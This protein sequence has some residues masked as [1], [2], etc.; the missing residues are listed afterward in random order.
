MLSIIPLLGLLRQR[1]ERDSNVLESYQLYL[2]GP[3]A[4][5]PACATS[6]VRDRFVYFGIPVLL[7]LLCL[8]RIGVNKHLCNLIILIGDGKR[9][10]CQLAIWHEHKQIVINDSRELSRGAKTSVGIE[11]VVRA[12]ILLAALYLAFR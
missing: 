3:L 1:L 7:L 9:F 8:L 11:A 2:P 5:I 10:A 4:S 6:G 12:L